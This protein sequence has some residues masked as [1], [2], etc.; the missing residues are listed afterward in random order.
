MNGFGWICIDSNKSIRGIPWGIALNEMGELPPE[1][2][3]VSKKGNKAYVY[4]L[5]YR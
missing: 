4:D 5:T 2:E 3:W 1:G